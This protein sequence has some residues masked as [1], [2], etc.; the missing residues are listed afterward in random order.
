MQV[1]DGG[2]WIQFKGFIKAS[3]RETGGTD[4]PL[5]K[6]AWKIKKYKNFNLMDYSSFLSMTRL[7]LRLIVKVENVK[8][9]F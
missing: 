7:L 6:S 1:A 8:I 5:S 4:F 9:N 2:V 3:S